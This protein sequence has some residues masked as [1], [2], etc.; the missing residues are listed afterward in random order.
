[1]AG[2]RRRASQCQRD[3]TFR[4]LGEQRWNARRPRLVAPKPRGTFVTEPVLPAPDHRLG[5]SGRLHDLSRAATIG[6]Q[7]NDLCPPNM[8]LWAIAVSD[9]CLKLAAIGPAQV[10]VRSLVH[11][12]VSHMRDL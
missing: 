9:Y 10:E 4:H 3:H 12:K 11:L 5:L 2:R 6:R 8:L 1:M 7:K